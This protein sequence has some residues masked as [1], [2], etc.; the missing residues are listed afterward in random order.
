MNV[1]SSGLRRQKFNGS[2]FEI[3]QQNDVVLA[4]L[5]IHFTLQVVVGLKM[6]G[7]Y[8]ERLSLHLV[9]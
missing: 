1:L 8:P 2:L 7:R 4:N 6:T 3:F 5:V 9:R